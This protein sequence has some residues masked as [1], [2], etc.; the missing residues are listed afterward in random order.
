M[1]QAGKSLE[2][3]RYSANHAFANPTGQNYDK[4][5]AQTAWKRTLA[6]LHKNLRSLSSMS[7]R[8]WPGDPSCS[9]EMDARSELVLGRPAAGPGGPA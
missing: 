6:F 1:K 3:Y 5:D 9:R 4:E 7:S 8:A 2:D